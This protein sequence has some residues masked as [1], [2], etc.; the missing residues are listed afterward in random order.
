MEVKH[1]AHCTYRI[2]YHIVFVIKYRKCL[3]TPPIFE[4]FKTICKEIEE[5]YYFNF[6][7]LG[8]DGDHLHLVVEAAPRYAPSRI[9][10]I[11]KSISAIQI[12]KQFPEIREELWGGEFW[13]D[14][15]HVDT[16]GDG[17]GLEEVKRY[18][19]NQGGDPNHL[20]LFEFA[21]EA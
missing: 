1:P 4:F 13:S 18:V 11:C 8:S 6:E 20:T 3:I 10:Q 15:G 2:R 5:R 21:V 9:I 19:K 7:A 16:V 12:F 17:R 14:G